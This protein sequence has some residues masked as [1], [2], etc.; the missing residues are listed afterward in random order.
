[1]GFPFALHVVQGLAGAQQGIAFTGIGL[2]RQLQGLADECHR[3]DVGVLHCRSLPGQPGVGARPLLVP[4]LLPVVGQDGVVWGQARPLAEAAL[5]PLGH[6][7]VQVL[8]LRGE[9]RTIGRFLGHLVHE[10]VRRPRRGHLSADQVVRLHQLELRRQRLATGLDGVCVG[11][12]IEPKAAPDDAGHLEGQPVPL[13]Q[14]VQA[15]EGQPQE[16]VGQAQVDAQQGSVLGHPPAA[17]LA[18]QAAALLQGIE[19]GLGE[20]PGAVAWVLAKAT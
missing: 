12:G 14:A 16:G 3:F 6:R 13:R 4:A 9:Q 1:M 17:I 2:G 5:V 7:A 19:Q 15:R 8:S 10:A 18:A 20:G 11:Q